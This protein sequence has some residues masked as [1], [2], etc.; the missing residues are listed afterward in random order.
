M[1]IF[2]EIKA[3]LS[4]TGAPAFY[5]IEDGFYYVDVNLPHPVPV[6]SEEVTSFSDI[7]M[8]RHLPGDRDDIFLR[9]CGDQFHVY[10]AGNYQHVKSVPNI[11]NIRRV[12]NPLAGYNLDQLI[13]EGR[14]VKDY[15]E[16]TICSNI[17]MAFSDRPITDDRLSDIEVYMHQ[18]AIASSGERLQTYGAG[19]CIIV[20]LYDRQKHIALMTHYVPDDNN[21]STQ[22][23]Q[24]FFDE[25]M[26]SLNE[27]G[28]DAEKVE[29]YMIGG[30][31]DFPSSVALAS[32][33]KQESQRRGLRTAYEDILGYGLNRSAS[34]V[35][36][37]S[38]GVVYNYTNSE[39]LYPPGT[40]NQMTILGGVMAMAGMPPEQKK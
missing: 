27:K 38:D 2:D 34:V 21:V 19:P 20:V 32:A 5:Q 4:D 22:I 1:S 9:K 13:K 12:G 25:A 29:V 26:Q 33:L 8:N 24:K 39:S 16:P 28:A 6:D 31:Q 23:V 15:D 14:L 40:V 3:S 10:D 11:D 37:P 35:F 36:D 17:T 18:Y 7:L 30:S